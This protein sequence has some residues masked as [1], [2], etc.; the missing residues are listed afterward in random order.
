MKGVV[1]DATHQ[2]LALGLQTA[3]LLAAVLAAVVTWL[4]GSA[5]ATATRPPW[6]ASVASH[7]PAVYLMGLAVA[8]RGWVT[9]GLLAIS[10]L[11]SIV[12][13]TLH[14]HEMTAASSDV[15]AANVLALWLGAH[16]AVWFIT[17]SWRGGN[18]SWKGIAATLILAAAA[19]FGAPHTHM[20][21]STDAPATTPGA[22]LDAALHTAWHLLVYA[23]GGVVITASPVLL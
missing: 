6:S 16:T 10:T 14:E 12:Y 2:P 9:A 11:L 18:G 1:W 22:R 7:L 4:G 15:A 13:H 5:T 3:F 8:R 20:P 19:A 17:T 21:R 23:A